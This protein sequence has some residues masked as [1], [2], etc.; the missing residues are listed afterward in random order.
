MTQTGPN[1]EWAKEQLALA[2]YPDGFSTACHIYDDDQWQDFGALMKDMWE[3]IG[4]EVEMIPHSDADLYSKMH[5]RSYNLIMLGHGSQPT[6]WEWNVGG[7]AGWNASDM[8]DER[9]D[10]MWDAM[11]AEADP[12][13]RNALTKEMMVHFRQIHN[14]VIIPGGSQVTYWQPWVH[15]YNGEFQYGYYLWEPVVSHVWLD[16]DLKFERT[17]LR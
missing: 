11:R 6:V 15:N 8:S 3:D 2:G 4:V 13:A 14:A 1:V 16:N 12:V 17:G 10:E 7:K 5:D 9:Y